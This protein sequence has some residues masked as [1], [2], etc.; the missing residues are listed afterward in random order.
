MEDANVK[1]QWKNNLK[2]PGEKIISFIFRVT[3]KLIQIR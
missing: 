3:L 2:S 1:S